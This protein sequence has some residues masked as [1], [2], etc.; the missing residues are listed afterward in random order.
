MSIP[1]LIKELERMADIAKEQGYRPFDISVL[2]PE[3]GHATGS[4]TW[5]E[6]SDVRFERTDSG[7]YDVYL[8]E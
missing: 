5:T 4:K 8:Y 7:I 3:H 1:E 6:V 2:L